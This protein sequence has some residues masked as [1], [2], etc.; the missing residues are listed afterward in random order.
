MTNALPARNE[1]PKERQ[2]DIESVFPS[3]EK[4]EEAF[5][6]VEAQITELSR[7]RGRLGESPQALLKATDAIMES[8]NAFWRVSL[9]ARM[10][11]AGDA[12][13]QQASALVGRVTAQG[14]RLGAA[15]SFY[16][17]EILAIDDA[18]LREFLAAEP[19]LQL[20]GHY[21]DTIRELK[22]HTR[23]AEVEAVLAQAGVLRAGPR[24]LYDSLVNADLKFV[25]IQSP[26]GDS[27]LVEQGR[28]K[29]LLSDRN[30]AVRKAA[31]ESYADGY[32]AVKNTLAASLLQ[33]FQGR[34]FD[35]RAR[36]YETALD[37]VLFPYRIP[38]SVPDG[39]IA[40]FRQNL[41]VWHRYW[42]LLKKAMHADDLHVYDSALTDGPVP[43]SAGVRQISWDDAV[44]ILCESMKPLGPEYVAAMRKG[45]TDERWVD[46]WPNQGKGSGAFSTG[47]RGCRPFIMMNYD[48]SIQALST[49][50]HEVGHSMHSHLCW[51]R[52][53]FVYSGYGSFVAETASNFNQALV[54]AHLLATSTDREF[55][56]AVLDE[57]FSNFFRY[58]F[59]MP[60][61]ARFEMDCYT[62]LESG[63][64]PTADSM[65]ETMVS[66]FRE[67]FGPDVAIDE[68]RVGITWAQFLHLYVGYYPFQYA[69]GISAANALA[70]KVLSEGPPAAERY[71]GALAAGGSMYPLDV[72]R[73]AGV[74]MT[75]TAPI[76]TAFDVLSGYVDQL[77][78]LHETRPSR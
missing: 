26:S 39:L 69:T 17:P 13:D 58:L 61:L 75:S 44:S 77:E 53:P 68:T 8:E 76:Q 4:W 70:K 23:S 57:T 36:N 43:L 34:L 14:A 72:L 16:D 74:D 21:F 20:Y 45:L 33:A 22:P 41:P 32:L 47:A 3:V 63:V 54:R 56:L 60:T 6:H 19:G 2:W 42:A 30:R 67:A 12:G 24:Q 64:V 38:R 65:S 62:K 46:A 48:H 35:A 5:G 31:W 18:T 15:V 37:S 28:I 50:A 66:L 10:L 29:E 9:Y 52:Q 73:S 11:R 40:V 25:G 27:L 78:A 59:V 49:L 1:V 55:R 71:C 51:E 7:Y